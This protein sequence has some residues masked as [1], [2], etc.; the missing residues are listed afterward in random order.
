MRCC[1]IPSSSKRGAEHERHTRDGTLTKPSSHL[2]ALTMGS[3]DALLAHIVSRMQ[4]DID[5]LVEQEVISQADG[6]VM[7]AKLP[8]SQQAPMMP[9]PTASPSPAP[10]SI[11]APVNRRVPQPP[12]L[13]GS[14][15]PQARSL[16]PYNENGQVSAFGRSIFLL[17]HVS[18]FCRRLGIFPSV[19]EKQ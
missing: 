8:T 2:P 18:Y 10:T 14:Q 4:T 17:S 12:T 16:W 15:V 7:S 5:F 13:P 19:L 11:P 9:T 3:S 1:Q 6:Q